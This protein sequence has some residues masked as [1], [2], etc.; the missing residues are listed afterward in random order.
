[1]LYGL[2]QLFHVDQ[3]VSP[4]DASVLVFPDLPRHAVAAMEF[5]VVENV[6]DTEDK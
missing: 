4:R 1:M 2:L 3:K 5:L 6:S